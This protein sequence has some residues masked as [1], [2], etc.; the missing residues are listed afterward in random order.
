M[1][2]FACDPS[3]DASR[4][5]EILL[6]LGM[7]LLGALATGC[8]N[9]SSEGVADSQ[10]AATTVKLDFFH[11]PLPDIPLPNDIATIVDSTSATGRRI[12]AS[13]IA[14]TGFE[15]RVRDLADHL[16]G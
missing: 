15:R 2:R 14:P 16:D 12:N 11:K 6:A 1:S 7:C 13:M 10:P 9:S 4:A 3:T 5:R 8:S